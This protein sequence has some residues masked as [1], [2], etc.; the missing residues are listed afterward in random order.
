MREFILTFCFLITSCTNNTEVTLE[1]A[2]KAFERS[3]YITAL[4]MYTK[5]AETKKDPLSQF[6][7]SLMYFY[8]KGVESDVTKAVYWIQ[9]S[10]NQNYA[11]AQ[12]I[13][14]SMY[15]EGKGVSK[16]DVQ[17]F[18]WTLKAAE[19]NLDEAQFNIGKAY[20]DGIGVE[21]NNTKALYWYRKS[22]SQGNK[23]ANKVLLLRY[24]GY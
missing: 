7:L 14:G 4:S 1:N 11:S 2:E 21:K 5:I 19:Q 10:A 3:D 16:D 13:L 6:N 18:N 23:S 9:K 17:S 15:R 8:G 24:V 20:E 12:F 22:A